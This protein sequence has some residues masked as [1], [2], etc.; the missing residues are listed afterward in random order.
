MAQDGQQPVAPPRTGG[1]ARHNPFNSTRKE[2]KATWLDFHNLIGVQIVK[3]REAWLLQTAA[4]GVTAASGG[5]AGAGHGGPVVDA[6]P[7]VSHS[8]HEVEMSGDKLLVVL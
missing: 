3:D 8:N 7:P 6:A 2:R 1:N 5:L 4:V